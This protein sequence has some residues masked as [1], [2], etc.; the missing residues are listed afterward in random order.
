MLERNLLWLNSFL[1]V[2]RVL[3]LVSSTHLLVKT[4]SFH[5]KIKSTHLIFNVWIFLR[6]LS[7]HVLILDYVAHQ[8][9]FRAMDTDS[10]VLLYKYHTAFRMLM[11]NHSTLDEYK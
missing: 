2:L 4:I 8:E 9:L 6:I 5:N 10:L 11:S 3:I 7:N 1:R